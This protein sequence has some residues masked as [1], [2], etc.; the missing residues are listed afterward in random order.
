MTKVIN[1]NFLKHILKDTFFY[2]HE[3]NNSSFKN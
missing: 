3:E 1:N 2:G